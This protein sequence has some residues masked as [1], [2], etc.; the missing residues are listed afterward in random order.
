[1]VFVGAINNINVGLIDIY[2]YI[3]PRVPIHMSPRPAAGLKFTTAR[4][5]VL[6]VCLAR[7]YMVG[8]V[9]SSCLST[10]TEKGETRKYKSEAQSARARRTI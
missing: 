5:T 9:G 2:D 6:S 8:V 10:K 7:I 1:M 4:L 3:D